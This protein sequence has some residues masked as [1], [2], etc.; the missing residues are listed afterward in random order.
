M[1][2]NECDHCKKQFDHAILKLKIIEE[3]FDHTILKL[4]I[5]DE[6]V[7]VCEQ[8]ICDACMKS[9]RDLSPKKGMGMNI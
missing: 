5:L 1:I 3:R 9:L 4:R 2:I 8:E 7:I 6:R